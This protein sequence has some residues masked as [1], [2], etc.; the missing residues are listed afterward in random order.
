MMQ[1]RIVR[2]LSVVLVLIAASL[3]PAAENPPQMPQPDDA[4]AE[5]QKVFAEWKDLISN[6]KSLQDKYKE[7]A[8]EGRDDLNKQ[9]NE[10]IGKGDALQARLIEAA[11]KAYSEAPNADKQVTALLIDVLQEGMA[12]D[13]YEEVL[14]LAEMLWKNNCGDKQVLVMA[15]V[16]AF[17]AGDFDKA[18]QYLKEARQSSLLNADTERFL[19]LIPQ[20]KADWAKEQKIRQAEAKADN[21]PRVLLKTTKGDIEVELFENEAP[22][23]VAN[24]ISLVEKKFYDGTPF[25]RVLPGFMAQGGDPKGN[26]SGGPGYTIKCECYEPN[27]RLHFRG[28]LSMAHAGRD[29]GGSQ[30]FITFMPTSHLDGKHTVFG[31]VINGMDVLAKLQRFDPEKS[32]QP[33]PDKIVEAK[34]IRKQNHDYAPQTGP[35]K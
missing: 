18:E 6:L 34:V 14:P 1:A 4:A 2:L 32:N 21:L 28:S 13:N 15:G 33:K 10:T 31:R 12:L 7:A 23:T 25:H 11:R 9:W 24:F 19:K 20:Y 30:F 16:A 26:G 29:T 27:H 3:M 5:Y 8:P 22:N 17:A 35:E